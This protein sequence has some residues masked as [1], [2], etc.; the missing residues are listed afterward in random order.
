MT[1]L[2]RRAALAGAAGLAGCASLPLPAVNQAREGRVAVEG[3]SVVWRRFGGGPKTPL[4][5]VHGGPGVPSDY[6]EPLGALGDERPVYFWDQLGCGRSDRPSNPALWTRERFVSEMAAVREALGLR[7]VHI[8]GQSWGTMLTPD[9]L[10]AHGSAGVRSVILAGPVLSIQR[11]TQDVRA[12]V[13]ELPAEHRA[14]IAAAEASGQFDTPA[15]QAATEAFYAVHLARAPTPETGPLLQRTF[16][17]I[18][19][20]CYVT[21]NGPSEFSPIG[22][23]RTYERVADMAQLT[24]PFLYLSGEYD[25][26]TPAASRAYAAATPHAEVAVIA[27]AGHLT[28]IDAPDATNHVVRSFLRRVEAA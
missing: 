14:A 9:Y 27:E 4:L 23:L 5:V 13:A 16:E 17:G 19:Q 25:T 3:G 22:S 8:L 12:M 6:L 15:Y 20:E 28:T 18:G 26:C 2:T 7:R 1:D 24:M 21:M 11:Y 10:L